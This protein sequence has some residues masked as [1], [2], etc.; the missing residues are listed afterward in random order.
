MRWT[1]A[2]IPGSDGRTTNR[3]RSDGFS[4]VEI[5][6]A[7]VL[8]LLLLEGVLIL[9]SVTNRV[10]STQAALSRLQENG[11]ISLQLV[12]EDLRLAGH[13]PCGSH[14]RPLVFTDT[15][16][17]HI[18]GAPAS[19]GAP[20]GWPVD[21]AY[22]LAGEVFINGNTCMGST[23]TPGL[24]ASL[25]LPKSGNA[26]GDRIPGADVLTVRYLQGNGWSANANGSRQDCDANGKVASITIRKLPGDPELDG[27]KSSHIAMLA[28]C[29][30]AEIFQVN[31]HGDTLQPLAG[32]FGSPACLAEESPLRLFD[33]DTQLRTSVYFLQIVADDS[34]SGH[35]IAALMRR[36]NGVT[37][38]LARGVE[39]LDFRYSLLDAAGMAHWLTAGEVAHAVTKDDAELLCKPLG[40][41]SARTCDWSDI[42][43]VGISMLVNTVDDLPTDS[44]DHAWDYRYSM[45]GDQVRSPAAVMPVTGLPAGRMLRREFQSVIALKSSAE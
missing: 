34:H 6:I 22:R 31:V 23:C 11:R 44:A 18:A 19:A 20:D 40:E 21:V 27:F 14:A 28:S 35:R 43:A 5:M 15:L 45:D 24:A 39:R 33:V 26:I 13:L 17:S 12:A 10:S 42:D 37:G 1:K 3:A 16:A 30:A 29:T 32:K 9:F 41:D 7:M 38:E 4:L 25:G 2:R 8:G 36:I